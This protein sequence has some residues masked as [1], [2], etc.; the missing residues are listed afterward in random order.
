[1][2]AFGLDV[3]HSKL[4]V[5]SIW[6]GELRGYDFMA[7][8]VAM[9]GAQFAGNKLLVFAMALVFSLGLDGVT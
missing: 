2:V 5:G 8:P 3:P 1:M 7:D 6:G 4:G 9:G